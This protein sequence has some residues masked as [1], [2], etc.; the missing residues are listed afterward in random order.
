MEKQTLHLT[1]KN[2]TFH[3]YAYIR[4]VREIIHV[5]LRTITYE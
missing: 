1:D 5:F 4:Y 2:T 3:K